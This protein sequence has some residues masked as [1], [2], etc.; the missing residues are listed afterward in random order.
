MDAARVAR[1]VQAVIDAGDA[2]AVPA[3]MA[4]VRQA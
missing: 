3:S 2:T 1:F 4:T